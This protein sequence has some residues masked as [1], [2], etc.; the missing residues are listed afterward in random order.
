MKRFAT[1]LLALALPMFAHAQNAIDPDDVVEFETI[2]PAVAT[3]SGDR[4][5]VIEL[6]WYGCPHCFRLEP[7]IEKWLEEKPDD[8][9]YIRLP[10]I[11]PN[12][13]SWE[14]H[15]RAFY[16][17]EALGVL[18]T[19]HR[20][21]FDGLHELRLRLDSEDELADYFEENGVEEAAFRKAFN[22]FAVRG[23]VGRAKVLTARYQIDGVPTMVVDGHYSTGPALAGS[24]A[25]TLPV[26]D[27]LI[28][29][30]RRERAAEAK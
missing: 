9:V 14:M 26:T 21:L 2:A 23:K 19:M 12:R 28:E 3:D 6:F 8:V 17:A 10:A 20:P 25:R 29:K 4:I 30:V 5:E 24:Y 18:D 13:P 1:L 11:F 27:A 7:H 15:A 16:T 22:S